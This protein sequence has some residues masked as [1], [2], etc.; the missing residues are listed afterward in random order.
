ML[1]SRSA[2]PVEKRDFSYENDRGAHGAP[3]G[4]TGNAAQMSRVSGWSG[5]VGLGR[6]E[7]SFNVYSPGGRREGG[8]YFISSA[9]RSL[10]THR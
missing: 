2:V 7:G 10:Q 4:R 1:R 3:G 6:S 8:R 5:C 9:Y